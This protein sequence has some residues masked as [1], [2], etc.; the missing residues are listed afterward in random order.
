MRLWTVGETA[1]IH[2]RNQ[3]LAQGCVATWRNVM[4]KLLEFTISLVICILLSFLLL[5][6]GFSLGAVTLQLMIIIAVIGD[7]ALF[8][9]FRE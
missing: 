4:T 3:T 9:L 8:W 6:E 7:V 2:V 5:A 1:C